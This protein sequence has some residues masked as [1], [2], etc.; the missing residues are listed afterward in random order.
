MQRD[1]IGTERGGQPAQVHTQSRT[2]V[3]GASPAFAALGWIGICTKVSND[4]VAP[5]LKLRAIREGCLPTQS[6]PR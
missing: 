1:I 2:N 6:S 5:L 4:F 3:T